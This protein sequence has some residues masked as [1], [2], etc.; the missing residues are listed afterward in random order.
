MSK[1]LINIFKIYLFIKSIS[2]LIFFIQNLIFSWKNALFTFYFLYCGM[3]M[4]PL[5]AIDCSYLLQQKLTNFYLS[6]LLYF[7]I[8]LQTFFLLFNQIHPSN[9]Q[10]KLM[11]CLLFFVSTTG[12][13]YHYSFCIMLAEYW[14]IFFDLIQIWSQ[15]I[16]LCFVNSML[17]FI[18][19]YSIFDI[20][21]FMAFNIVF[22]YYFYNSLFRFMVN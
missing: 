3:K 9:L 1:K 11:I 19:F 13:F 4:T 5:I 2:E 12:I 10:T 6:P 16:L 20:C 17:I 7:I 18:L 8:K 22:W 21:F 15:V 14:F